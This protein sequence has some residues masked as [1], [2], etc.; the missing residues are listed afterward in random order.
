MEGRCPHLSE[1]D[2][3][4]INYIFDE[5]L[6]FS[7]TM[8]PGTRSEFRK[9]VL[10]Y[11]NIIPS[12]KLFFENIKYLRPIVYVLKRLLPP[13][14]K[15]TLRKM[16][17]RYYICPQSRMFPIQI[18]ENN[19]AEHEHADAKYGFWSAYR[20]I[21]LFAMRHFY[22]LSEAW[23]RGHS[24]YSRSQQVQDSQ[25]LWRRFKKV[26]RTLGFRIP[27]H[28]SP[29]KP[30]QRSPEFIAIHSLLTR[31]RPP[32][33]FDYDP[34]A[35]IDCSNKVADML[36]QM[37]ERRVEAP[38]PSLVTDIEKYWS[39]ESRCGMTDIDS[40][41]SDQKYL[42]FHN[43]YSHSSGVRARNITSFAV[44][45]DM[46]L[47]LFPHFN[48]DTDMEGA[49]QIAT[50]LQATNTT[51]QQED[52]NMRDRE[53]RTSS[54]QFLTLPG[55]QQV[56]QQL[57]QNQVTTYFANVPAISYP[58]QESNEPVPQE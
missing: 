14:F 17:Q 11:P 33:L 42:F 57:P 12:L 37:K 28:Y 55:T 46:F 23:P 13:N 21:F 40:F 20:Q 8:D 24:C 19:F 9:T 38:S 54:A 2:R 45:R 15:S 4:F 44:K 52:V 25:E 27:G 32:G 36:V 26:S 3:S 5:N 16:M 48:E 35:L 31:L 47:T 22:G 56:P 6:A 10:D 58:P 1:A 7:H 50:P 41:F 51:S 30:E 43:I 39:L 29:S 18:S 34:S 49:P 53:S